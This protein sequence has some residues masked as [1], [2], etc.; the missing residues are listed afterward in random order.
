[1]SQDSILISVYYF[2]LTLALPLVEVC[3]NVLQS[4]VTAKLASDHFLRE[5]AQSEDSVRNLVVEQINWPDLWTFCGKLSWRWFLYADV[6]WHCQETFTVMYPWEVEKRPSDGNM[7]SGIEELLDSLEP[8]V[9]SCGAT[10]SP[11]QRLDSMIHRILWGSK[12]II[13]IK[14]W[15]I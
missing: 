2:S 15:D 13:V 7:Y 10:M 1:M 4:V 6:W 14:M 8:E 3:W 9:S 12:V 5:S 11:W